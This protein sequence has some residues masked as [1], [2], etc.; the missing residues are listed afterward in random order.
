MGNQILKRRFTNDRP[1]SLLFPPARIVRAVRWRLSSTAQLATQEAIDKVRSN[2][3]E[4]AYEQLKSIYLNPAN[5]GAICIFV[6]IR[7]EGEIRSM[8]ISGY[9]YSKYTVDGKPI[10][11]L[12]ERMWIFYGSKRTRVCR[13]VF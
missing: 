12:N 4:L 11:G 6:F 13:R 8:V 7:D 10:D 1:S 2:N 9:N 3:V 5:Y